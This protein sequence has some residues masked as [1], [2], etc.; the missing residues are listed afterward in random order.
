MCAR[1]SANDGGE[2]LPD[3]ARS[4]KALKMLEL[5]LELAMTWT[6]FAGS[7]PAVTPSI[8]AS[9]AAAA[10][11]NAIMLLHSLATVPVPRAPM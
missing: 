8:I 9:E 5:P 10:L 2:N 7:R 6:S 11:Q 4:E 1:L 3:R